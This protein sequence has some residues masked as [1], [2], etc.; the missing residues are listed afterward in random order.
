MSLSQPE[1]QANPTS[2]GSS[3]LALSPLEN[4][5]R[6]FRGDQAGCPLS[7]P[8]A[9]SH[10]TY[11]TAS[12]HLFIC[13][14]PGYR[15]HGGKRQYLFILFV[16]LFVFCLLGAALQHMKF[17]L[18]VKSELQLPAYTTATAMPDLSHVCDL[19][20]SSWQCW[21][22]NPLS[23][24]R[25]RT[26]ILMDTSWIRYCRALMGTPLFIFL[27]PAPCDILGTG[28]LLNNVLG[29]N[30]SIFRAVTTRFYSVSSVCFLQL[31]F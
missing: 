8:S 29:G 27:F 28:Q 18:G 30:R 15:S 26:H 5:L 16:H 20:H 12:N 24:T 1:Q 3:V 7:A 14:A 13:L 10:S 31:Y 11:C 9:A 2:A 19:H 25:D 4:L 23:G 6:L 17:R 22:L 21:I